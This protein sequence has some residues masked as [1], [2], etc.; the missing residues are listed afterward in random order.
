MSAED[1]KM[2]HLSNKGWI[3]NILFNIEN[4]KV[5]NHCHVTEKYKVVLNEVVILILG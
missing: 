2:F 5:R 3:C 4:N 1:E